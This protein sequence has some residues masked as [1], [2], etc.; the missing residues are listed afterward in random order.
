LQT[1]PLEAG[2]IRSLIGTRLALTGA[3]QM[4]LQFGVARIARATGRRRATRTPKPATKGA[5]K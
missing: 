1:Q 3:P 4:L 2:T 5:P